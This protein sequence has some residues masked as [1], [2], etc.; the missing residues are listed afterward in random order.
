[1]SKILNIIKDNYN[2]DDIFDSYDLHKICGINQKVI[3]M[4]L[5]RL[6]NIEVLGCLSGKDYYFIRSNEDIKKV[7]Q[8]INEDIDKCNLKQKKYKL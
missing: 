3:A 6:S 2:E 7:R 5:K 4:C 8:K 1:M